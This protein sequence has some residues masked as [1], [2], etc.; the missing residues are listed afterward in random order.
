[1]KEIC[2]FRMG[3]KSISRY[4]NFFVCTKFFHPWN[5]DF[6]TGFIFIRIEY[7]KQCPN[8]QPCELGLTL[9]GFTTIV[10]AWVIMA[11]IC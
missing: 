9:N 7:S 3:I 2:G 10:R 4:T 6:I 1:M 11:G 8:L 5:Q